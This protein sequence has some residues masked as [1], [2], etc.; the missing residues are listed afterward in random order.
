MMTVYKLTEKFQM[1]YDPPEGWRYGFPKVYDPKKGE[2]LNQTLLRDGYPE[3]L[4]NQGL[5][6]YCRFIG[7]KE[8]IEGLG[9]QP[10]IPGC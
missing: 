5:G 2:T 9:I 8:E 10:Q 3:E 1:L 6:K 4:I 7:P